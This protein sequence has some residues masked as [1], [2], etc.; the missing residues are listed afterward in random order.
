MT[1]VIESCFSAVEPLLGTKAACTAVGRSRATHYRRASP[2]RVIPRTGR[3]APA[4][5]LTGAEA[6]QVLA[7]LRSPRFADSSPAQVY[8]TLLD[9][10]IYLASESSFYRILRAAGEVRERR[11]QASHPAKKKPE[12]MAAKPLVV[13]SWDITKLKGPQRGDYYD[14]YVVLDIFSRYVVAWC[15]APSESGELAKELIADAIA[16]HQVP[17]GQLTIHADRGSSMTSNPVT[18]LYTFLGI[19]RS[20]SRPHVSNDNC[21]SEAQFKTLKYCPAFPGASAASRTPGRSARRSSTTTTMNTATPAS[22]TT[23]PRRF[24][25]PPPPKYALSGPRPCRPPTPPA[26]NDSAIVALSR[27]APNHGLDQRAA[28]RTGNHSDDAIRTCLKSLGVCLT[29]GVSGGSFSR[30]RRTGTGRRR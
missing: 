27:P 9:E 30:S 4:N 3:P 18:G 24:T 6:S 10:G 25:T 13:W 20:H 17:P 14:C 21:Y 8:F 16:R 22:A 1:A 2:A 15:V 28:P 23:R 5:K 11:R 26:P 12:L 19:R 29:N 7:V